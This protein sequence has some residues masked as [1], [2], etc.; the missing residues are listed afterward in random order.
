MNMQIFIKK[1]LNYIAIGLLALF[2]L[3]SVQSCNRN[4]SNKRLK[5][6]IIS[7]SDSLNKSYGYDLDKCKK[8]TLQLEYEVKLANAEAESANKRASAIQSTAEKIRENTTI[9]I[10]K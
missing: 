7:L 8:Y 6:E 4:M 5:K 3:K 2:L 10:E 9:K 1:N